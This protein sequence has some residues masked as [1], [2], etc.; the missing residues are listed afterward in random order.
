MAHKLTGFSIKIADVIVRLTSE[1]VA[2]EP[3]IFY[4]A[5]VTD[6]LSPDID[7]QVYCQGIPRISPQ[8]K[9]FDSGGPWSLYSW[10][11]KC[12]F[13]FRSP[14]V[15]PSPYE[16]AIFDPDFANGEIHFPRLENMQEPDLPDPL[17]YPLDE[18]LMVNY[19][20]QGRGIDIH[21]CGV[22][23]HAFGM[24]FV[25]VSGAGK[26]TIAKLWKSRNAKVLCDDRIILRKQKGG[27]RL[28]GTPWHGD[29]RM[30]IPDEAPLEGLFFLKQARDNRIVSLSP[31]DA[32]TRLTVRCFPTLYRTSGMEFTLDFITELAQTVPCYELQFTPDQ[33]AIDEVL[34]HVE[35]LAPSRR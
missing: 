11:G 10:Q 7:I 15:S 2:L 20:A 29:A 25:G 17:L 3:H 14:A 24:A 21:A 18:L 31:L 19:L 35:S 28:Y 1:D 32:A 9:I 5:F 22:V 16:M 13:T 23:S 30:A 6:E 34:S 12:V 8:Q 27:F 4:K 26:S 33:R